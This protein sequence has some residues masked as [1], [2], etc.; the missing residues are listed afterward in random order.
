[1]EKE[2]ISKLKNGDIKAFEEAVLKYE[3]AIFGYILGMVNH[4]PTAEDLTQETFIKLYKNLGNIDLEKNFKSWLYKIATNT[5]Y[6]WLR[7]K[8]KSQELFIVDDEDNNFE[9]IDERRTYFNIADSHDLEKA[10]E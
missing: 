5:V 1:M 4:R 7:T 2:A 10:L 3:K 9:T 8:K 6:D